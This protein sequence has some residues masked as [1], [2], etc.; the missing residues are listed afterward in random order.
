MAHTFEK[1]RP[2]SLA[3]AQKTLPVP[4]PV[5]E[6]VDMREATYLAGNQAYRDLEQSKA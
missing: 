5:S 6:V 2:S 4:I 3:K 1:G